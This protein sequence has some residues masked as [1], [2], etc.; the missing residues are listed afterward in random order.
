MH[1]HIKLHFIHNSLKCPQDYA[2]PFKDVIMDHTTNQQ[3][4]QYYLLI[5]YGIYQDS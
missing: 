1:A 3:T 2:Q 5:L 4:L